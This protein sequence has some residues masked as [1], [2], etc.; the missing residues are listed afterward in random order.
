MNAYKNIIFK[1][2]KGFTWFFLISAILFLFRFRIIFGIVLLIFL[3]L[4][5]KYSYG[6]IITNN[7]ANILLN[8]MV[9][10]P[11]LILGIQLFLSIFNSEI[12]NLVTNNRAHM[13]EK[14]LIIFREINNIMVLPIICFSIAFSLIFFIL[15]LKK[16]N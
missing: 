6:K 12:Y 7:T 16:N 8:I 1:I 4:F 9:T 14:T 3:S 15:L 11:F 2:F 13:I 10:L 5:K